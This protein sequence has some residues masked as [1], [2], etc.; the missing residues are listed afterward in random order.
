MKKNQ[1]IYI[2]AITLLTLLN[3]FCLIYR[4]YYL[5]IY[6]KKY[7]WLY[8]SVGQSLKIEI[9][10]F[11]ELPYKIYYFISSNWLSYTFMVIILSFFIF[12]LNYSKTI[13]VASF[14][15]TTLINLLTIYFYI[16]YVYD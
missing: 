7:S 4:I 16:I 12:K 11:E 6:V 13:R 3:I 8:G 14:I 10:I 5:K 2:I 1:K 15:L 9:P